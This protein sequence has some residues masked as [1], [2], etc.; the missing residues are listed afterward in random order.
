MFLN[1]TTHW[2]TQAFEKVYGLTTDPKQLLLSPTKKEFEGDFTI[3]VF[4][5]VK[6][7]KISPEAIGEAIGTFMKENDA[8]IKDYNVVKG[9]LN[10]TYSDDF[11]IRIAKN[12]PIGSYGTFPK[13]G[14]KVM[15]EFSSPN[16][17]KPLHLGHIRNILLGWSCTKIFEANGYEVIKTQII[18]DRGIAI[19]KSML[20]WKNFANGNT[21]ASTSIKGDHFVGEYYVRFEKE[22]KL[23]YE[24]FQFTDMGIAVFE[25]NKKEGQDF[26]SFFKEYKNT[27]FNTYSQLGAE[28]KQMLLDWE[29]GDPNTIALWNQMNQWVYSGFETTYNTLGVTFDK[30]YYESDTYLLGKDAVQYG[31][32]K[33]VFYKKEDESIWVDLT[34]V[35]MDHKIVQRSDGTS[36]YMTQDLGTAMMRY[37]DFQV[38][39]MVYTVADE[40]DYHFQVLFEILKRLGEPYAD[41]LYHLSYGMVEL[42]QGKMKSREGTVVDA[43]DLIAEVIAEAQNNT[44]ERG[45]VAEMSIEEQNATV[46]KIGLGALKYFMIK[47]QPKKRMIFDPKESVDLQGQTGPYIQNAYVRIRSI[48]RKNDSKASNFDTYLSLQPQEKVLMQLVMEYPNVISQACKDY[49]PSSVANFAYSLAKEFHKFYHDVRILGAESEEAKSFRLHLCNIISDILQRSMAT[50]GIEMPERM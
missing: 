34:D 25:K 5:F 24:G 37:K 16:T 49:D 38:D 2:L 27:Y 50:L 17:N 39:N 12:I 33:N 13:N 43:D 35:G 41:G 3:V 46:K 19:C 28:A 14:K 6:E 30:V 8:D 11:W 23:E 31:L 42:P 15:V 20:A 36:V 45:E 47:V 10:M 29:A 48:L 21:P 40:Q 22:F 44:I 32:T 9:F 1:Q 18:N 4:P 7:L 26:E